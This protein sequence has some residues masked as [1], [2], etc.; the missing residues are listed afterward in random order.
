MKAVNMKKCCDLDYF[1]FYEKLE[2][3]AKAKEKNKAIVKAREKSNGENMGSDSKD[4]YM[5]MLYHKL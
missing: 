1:S 3:V 5:H 4:Y 2:P